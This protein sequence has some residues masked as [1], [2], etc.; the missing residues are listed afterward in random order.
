MPIHPSHGGKFVKAS[1]G[2]GSTPGA[3]TTGPSLPIAIIS[4]KTEIKKK[5]KQKSTKC[6]VTSETVSLPEKKKKLI[7]ESPDSQAEGPFGDSD[8]Q[9]R[10]G[11]LSSCPLVVTFYQPS[12]PL[13]RIA[14]CE[15][16]AFVTRN[17]HSSL[18]DV[19]SILNVN[20]CNKYL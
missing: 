2:G 20:N 13:L 7:S 4:P 5:K 16:E 14:F 8:A 12:A 19:F 3:A 10:A 1:K 18:F 6:T 11:E 17:S 9:K 15:H